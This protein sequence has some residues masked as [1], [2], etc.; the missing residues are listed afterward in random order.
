MAHAGMV[1]EEWQ[2]LDGILDRAKSSSVSLTGRNLTIADVVSVARYNAQTD[3]SSSAIERM[4]GGLN[5]LETRLQGGDIIYGVNTGFGGSADSR[6]KQI[7][8]LQRALIRELHYGVL[9][10]GGRDHHAAP[11]DET[12]E[13]HRR[14]LSLDI[15]S[16][17]S[18]LPRSWGRA[19]ILIRIN[20]LISGCL[21]VRPVIAERMQDLLRHDI[22]PMIPLRGSISAFGD[23]IPLSYVSGAIQGKPTIRVLSRG[24]Q[25]V[26]ADTALNRAG[27]QPVTIQA[28]EGLAITN[29][30][31][32]SAAVAALA[33]HDTQGLALLAQVLTAMST[34]ALNGTTESFHPFFSEARPHPGQKPPT[35][36]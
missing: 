34:E 1:L 6:T 27:L 20:S 28:K 23:L 9:P 31:A 3:I 29:G 35:T 13:I 11:L 4:N 30:T 22:V 15:G 12:L 10:H 33:L 14:D 7:A 21:A 32:V 8:E 17:R 25:D 16:D 24:E 19:A 2:L 26:Y 18:Y 36:Y 5:M